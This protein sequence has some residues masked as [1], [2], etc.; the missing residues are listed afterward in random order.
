MSLCDGAPLARAQNLMFSLG[1]QSRGKKNPVDLCLLVIANAAGRRSC[2]AAGSMADAV[3]RALSHDEAAGGASAADNPGIQ[4]VERGTAPPNWLGEVL[5]RPP[6]GLRLLLAEGVH[7]AVLGSDGPLAD[8]APTYPDA[9]HLQTVFRPVWPLQH[10][11]REHVYTDGSCIT[12][13]VQAI[14]SGVYVAREGEDGASYTVSAC[15][16]GPTNT[17]NRAELVALHYAVAT[18]DAPHLKILTDSLTSIYQIRKAMAQ[19]MRQ[20][21]NKHDML[22]QS[23]VCRLIERCEKGYRTDFRKVKSHH[24]CHGNDKADEVAKRAAHCT[25]SGG[26]Y[27]DAT[28][29]VGSKPYL[30]LWWPGRLVEKPQRQTNGDAPCAARPAAGASGTGC[31][32]QTAETDVYYVANLNSSL[33]QALVPYFGE[34]FARRKGIY[35]ELWDAL[36]PDID[37]KAAGQIWRMPDV[38]FS[39]ARLLLQYKWGL[40]WNMKLAK[41]YRICGPTQNFTNGNC[42][43]CHQPDSSGHI[44]GHCAY[45]AMC[46]LYIRR[47]DDAVKIIQR[48]VTKGALG[49]YY[50]AMDAG[51]LIELPDTVSGKRL[52]SWLVG[53]DTPDSEKMRPDLLIV[54]G[55]LL[56][57]SDA[58]DE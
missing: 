30:E 28:V 4:S 50:T 49:G 7:D 25:A 10:D 24:M 42:P 11:W 18:S 52:P 38:M 58:A 55:C 23:L 29:G 8:T 9:S 36:K 51:K 20:R 17:I 32:Q 3:A 40:L 22:L 15:G 34:G 27:H 16:E 26:G 44:M 35:H 48:Y 54:K 43:L 14:G 46:A 37:T 33:R 5:P 41:R 6:H 21:L 12:S 47:H 39:Q 1:D 19:P 53:E 56:Y 57:T 13:P 2:T 31:Q 45:P